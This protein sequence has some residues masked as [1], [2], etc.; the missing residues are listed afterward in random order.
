M[1]FISRVVG[2]WN[3]RL[4]RNGKRHG[5]FFADSGSGGKRA[6][7]A[8]AKAYRDE[9]VADRQA[10][11]KPPVPRPL[12]VVRDGSEYLQIRVPKPKGGTTTTEFSVKRHG[13]RKAKQMAIEA[14][15]AALAAA[16]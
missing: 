3:V 13:P 4:T 7:L 16:G 12:L 1:Q 5:K 8:K 14:F 9:L 6:A 2:G 11:M 15:K 10:K